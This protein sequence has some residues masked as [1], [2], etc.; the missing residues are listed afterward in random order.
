MYQ[1]QRRVRTLREQ[2]Q[3]KDLHLDLLR[4]KLAL[5][6]DNMKTKCLLQNERDE[7][8]M[9]VK[10]LVKQVD[11]LQLQL[12]D[13]KSQIRDL[14]SQLAEA[15]D[16]KVQTIV[17][18]SVV[19][20][21][22]LQITA[23]ERGRKIEE[24]QK[25][26]IES[27]TLRT[28]YNRKVTLLKDQVRQTGQTIEQERNISEHSVQLLRD[29]LARVKDNLSELQRRDAQ[30][31]SFKGSIAKILGVALPMPDYELISRLQKLVD[32]HHDFTLVSRRYDDPV[33]RLATRSPTAGSR[34]TRTP[35]RSRYDDSGY[36]DA[37][38]IDDII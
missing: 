37:V 23:L 35:D 31:Q 9:R 3:R 29:E 4:R 26:L 6:E 10:K 16:Y 17:K 21:F 27:E 32:A 30:L 24:L 34:C 7:A 13:G 20:F 1:L 12:S 15:A 25:R 8:N 18:P 33:L 19:L 14:N 22:L 38:D 28:K 2:V 36:T 5:Q 11:R